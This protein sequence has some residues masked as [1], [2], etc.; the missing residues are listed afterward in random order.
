MKSQ[1]K[2]RSEN[3]QNYIHYSL[4]VEAGFKVRMGSLGYRIGGGIDNGDYRF[5]EKL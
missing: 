2:I 3:V 4:N 5:L 1:F